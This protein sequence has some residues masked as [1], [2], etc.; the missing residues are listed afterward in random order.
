MLEKT[1]E[2]GVGKTTHN[3]VVELIEANPLTW[4]ENEVIKLSQQNI[5]ENN[6]VVQ[7]RM[8]SSVTGFDALAVTVIRLNTYGTVAHICGACLD[9][10]YDYCSVRPVGGGGVRKHSAHPS[11]CSS[12]SPTK[13]HCLLINYCFILFRVTGTWSQSQQSIDVGVATVWTVHLSTTR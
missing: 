7:R 10:T 11:L 5:P 9:L 4:A 3:K 6:A 13:R 8:M 12:F 1:E 2:M